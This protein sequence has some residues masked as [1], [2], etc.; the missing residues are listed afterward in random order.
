MPGQVNE[1]QLLT[2]LCLLSNFVAGLVAGNHVP[3]TAQAAAKYIA[4]QRI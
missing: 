1:R 3:Q 2:S 4:G